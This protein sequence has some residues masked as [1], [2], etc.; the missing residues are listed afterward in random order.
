M[1]PYV[2]S[3]DAAGLI[4]FL[5]AALG[6]AVSRRFHRADGS[7]MHAEVW[8]DDSV[9]MIG[10]KADAEPSTAHIHLY[11]ED[12]QAS[13]DRAVTA[14]ATVVQEPARSTPDD[15]LRGGVQDPSGTTWWLATQ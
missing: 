10:G 8:I 1:S 5:E 9:L 13:F 3:A 7:L 2:T 4:A 6:A 12:A 11:V 14:G 15:D